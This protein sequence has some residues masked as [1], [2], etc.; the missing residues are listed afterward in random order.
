MHFRVEL[1][2]V[3]LFTVVRQEKLDLFY[4]MVQEVLLF[5]PKTHHR[6]AN[7]GN[8]FLANYPPNLVKG[9]FGH[10][11][12]TFFARLHFFWFL[13]LFSQDNE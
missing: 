9:K 1:P 12:P 13:Q 5:K 10:S 7:Q 4:H 8:L 3:A 11:P 6:L 2:I